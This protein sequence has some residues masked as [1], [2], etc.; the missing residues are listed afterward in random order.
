MVKIRVGDEI[1]ERNLKFRL[2]LDFKGE[3]K[4][5]LFFGGKN[6]EKGAEEARE[7][8]VALLR[9]VPYQGITI[10]DIDSSQEAYL[11]YDESTGDEIAY[12]PVIVTLMADSIEDVAR[13]IMRDEF[14]KVEM[15]DPG[16]IVL[17]KQEVERFLF[18]V[19]DELRKYKS[20]LEKKLTTR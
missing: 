14:R 1:V 17:S 3:T 11:V 13:F 7:Q 2:R 15:L 20:T 8:N 12:A 5:K 4:N 18:K 10:E 19:N 9:N 16:Q 6:P